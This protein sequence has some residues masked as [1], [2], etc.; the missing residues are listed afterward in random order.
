MRCINNQTYMKKKKSASGL[1]MPQMDDDH[2]YIYIYNDR[3]KGN[4]VASR[5]ALFITAF[6]C[7][8]LTTIYGPSSSF[9][10]PCCVVWY[11]GAEEHVKPG[12][13]ESI[14]IFFRVFYYYIFFRVF[15]FFFPTFPGREVFFFFFSDTYAGLSGVV[16][17]FAHQFYMM[18]S[19]FL[20]K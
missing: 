3:I 10:L 18:F 8:L 7:F 12:I 17:A 1:N 16:S 6:C 13:R 19:P 4:F 9:S 11:T 5:K 20:S 2:T 14:V 15:F